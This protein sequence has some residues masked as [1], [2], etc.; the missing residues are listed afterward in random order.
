MDIL[1]LSAC[2]GNGHNSVMNSI[3]S[4]LDKDKNN[5]ML[6]PNFYEDLMPSNKIMS[7]FYNLLQV[8][9]IEMCKKY[10][11]MSTLKNKDGIEE[12]YTYWKRPL[13]DFFSQHHCDIIISTTPLINQ[14]IIKYIE[15]M[16][17]K[18][19]LYIVVT[20]PFNPIYPGFAVTGAEIYF[21]PNQ[22]IKTILEE[23]GIEKSSIII[24]GYPLNKNFINSKG[25]DKNI[26]KHDLFEKEKPTVL[27]NCGA[28]GSYH[29][30][31]I[32]NEIYNEFRQ[33]INIIVICGKNKVLYNLCNKRYQII[34]LGYVN[35]M[36]DILQLTD[37][38]ITKAGANT[39][40]ECLYTNTPVLIDATKGLLY[41]EEGVTQVL[42]EQQIG[43]IFWDL[44]DL[45]IKLNYIIQGSVLLE[46]KE[47][48]KKL[49]IRNGS[50]VIANK[51]LP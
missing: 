38:C 19:K 47:C 45:I 26:L 35:D 31:S 36:Y 9:S 5:V 46:W 14:Y 22:L 42:R 24:S 12:T 21:V 20:D 48:I 6:F 41:Q 18:I 1:I 25:G 49:G 11:Q 3:Y 44:S 50:D 27:I 37:V 30:I 43:D 32:I 51:I 10:T 17:I 16:N 2:T 39:F 34:V 33:K 23:A 13:M 15:E 4:Y 8:S 7:D 29:Y 28:Q 40:Y